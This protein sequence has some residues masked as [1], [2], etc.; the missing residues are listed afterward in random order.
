MSAICRGYHDAPRKKTV[1]PL[2]ARAGVR[3]RVLGVGSPG[4]A[5]VISQGATPGHL[6]LSIRDPRG[7]NALKVEHPSVRSRRGNLVAE[8]FRQ[9]LLWINAQYGGGWRKQ[10]DGGSE[11]HEGKDVS[12]P[13]TDDIPF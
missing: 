13:V 11:Q 8:C 3:A 4:G 7:R 2:L 5:A 1:R 10:K 9:A 12:T 6:A